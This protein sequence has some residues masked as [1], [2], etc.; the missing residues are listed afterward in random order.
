MQGQEPQSPDTT[1]R[2]HLG[3]RVEDTDEHRSTPAILPV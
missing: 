3:D 1:R 2:S